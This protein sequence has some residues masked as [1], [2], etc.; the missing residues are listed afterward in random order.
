MKK[1]CV[2]TGTRA[3]YGLLYPL[4]LRIKNEIDLQ[5]E[6][7][8]TGSHLSAE[9]GLTYKSIEADGFLINKKIEILL[10]SDTACAVSKAMGLAMISFG[11]YFETNRPD[12]IIVLG[13]RFEIFAA[14][15][16]AVVARI[17]VAHLHGGEVTEGAYDE[18]FRH[19]ITKMSTLHFTSCLQH[20]NRV[21]QLGEQPDNV[22]NVGAI[23]IENI[24]NFKMLTLMELEEA[25]AFKLDKEYAIV[26]YHPATLD[27][28]GIKNEVNE[29][30]FALNE[31]DNMFF[32]I[33]KANADN[34]GR[35]INH[36][37]DNFVA[38]HSDKFI[39]FTS[40]GQLRYLS[41]MNYASM[42]IGNS[43]SGIIEAP[44]FKIPTINI[45]N[46]QKGRLAADSVI[47]CIP[48]KNK[49]IDAINLVRTPEFKMKVQSIVNPYG[50]GYVSYK[51][52][53]IIKERMANKNLQYMK[54][55]YDIN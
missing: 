21:I 16:A 49:I 6:L 25:I 27:N 28:D 34:G 46:R 22:Y 32:I 17:P 40:L 14:T 2:I 20:K 8:V 47:N 39:C 13:D 9:F 4:M 11:E 48:V 41:A 19:S 18:F 43:S 1:I 23:G 30:L 36:I 24:K 29:L 51:I 52:I 31:I 3:E 44:S 12:I 42:V 38:E 53:E 54:S 15:S 7:V 5:L 50:E 33:T 45:G 26:T 10:S 55:F 37:I 35:E